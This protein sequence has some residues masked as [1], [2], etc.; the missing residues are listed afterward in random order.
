MGCG[1]HR[2]TDT[3]VSD[4]KAI[5]SQVLMV[6]TADGYEPASYGRTPIVALDGSFLVAE[7]RSVLLTGEGVKSARTMILY[8]A[9]SGALQRTF[10]VGASRF[11]LY[12][13]LLVASPHAPGFVKRSPARPP[14]YI[15]AAH[16]KTT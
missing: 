7:A 14:R 5:N 15:W 12:D 3:D 13:D 8:D 16:E 6:T 2:R 1:V 4:V 11:P 10:S 9:P